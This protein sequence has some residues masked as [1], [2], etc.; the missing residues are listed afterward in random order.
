MNK[1]CMRALLVVKS[2]LWFPA[3]ALK[4]VYVPSRDSAKAPRVVRTV[5]FARTAK[6]LGFAL[7]SATELHII[8][9]TYR[10]IERR[11]FT[12]GVK[13]TNERKMKAFI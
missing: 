5:F 13:E 2:T 10:R 3:V 7:G 6:K 11:Q 12:L 4:A 1:C 9:L 8:A